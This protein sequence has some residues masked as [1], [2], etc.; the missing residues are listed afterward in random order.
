[1]NMI[2]GMTDS[3]KSVQFRYR[4]AGYRSTGSIHPRACRQGVGGF[5]IPDDLLSY[6]IMS[7]VGGR[8]DR[9]NRQK[10][11]HLDN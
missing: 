6:I 3:D 10:R 4:L 2:A 7:I 11:T 9:M 5:R 1:M 8:I